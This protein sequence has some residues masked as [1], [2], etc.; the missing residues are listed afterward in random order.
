V[1]TRLLPSLQRT[2]KTSVSQ[3]WR[4]P[5][6]PEKSI[7]YL[8]TLRLLETS[9]TI[10]S[11]NLDEAIGLRRCGH[12]GKAYQA[13]SITPSLCRR[14]AKHLQLSLRAMISHAK[15]FHIVPIINPL[16]PEN[17]QSPKSRRA[18]SISNLCSRII[19]TQRSQFLHKLSTLLELV[20]DLEEAFGE[21]A[22]DLKDSSSPHPEHEWATLDSAHYDLNTC[23]RESIV[24][25]KCFFHAMPAEQLP[26]FIAALQKQPSPSLSGALLPKRHLAHRRMAL[27]KGQ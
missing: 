5:L 1:Q 2:N 23:L 22:S 7:P 15:H 6:S 17:F 14:L 27:L 13:L 18:A 8:H 20:E 12:L 3:N 19:L 26:E 24:L 4:S 16:D 10:F 25:L 11:I 9:Y 21:A